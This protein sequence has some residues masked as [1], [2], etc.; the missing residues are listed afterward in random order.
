MASAT[1]TLRESH[2]GRRLQR[3]ARHYRAALIACMHSL[4][5]D[6]PADLAE[7]KDEVERAVDRLN[8]GVD[9]V[10]VETTARTVQGIETALWRLKAGTYG[11][12][13][14]CSGRIAPARL[15][16][17]PFAERC[18]T[19]QEQRDEEGNQARR[20]ELQEIPCL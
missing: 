16:A 1:A 12:C 19:C 7:V 15:R 17:L 11:R 14:E 5:E 8:Q 20:R 10:L 2:P 13:T 18:R 4:K 9:A 6:G 3:L